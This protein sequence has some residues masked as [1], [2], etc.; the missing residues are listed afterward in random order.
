MLGLRPMPARTPLRPKVTGTLKRDGYVVEK[1]HFQSIP[2]VYVPA[3]LY[4]PASTS[5][6]LPAVLYLC[7]HGIGKASPGYQAH[8][9][10]FAQHGYV[11]MILDTIELG[12]SRGDHHGTYSNGRWDWISRGYTPAGAEVWNAMRA[13]DYLETRPDVDPARFGVTGISGGGGISWFL[14]AADERI[15]CAA[16]CCQTGSV[17]QHVVDRTMDLHCDCAFWIN[18]Y[19][20]CLP[21]IGALIA[22]RPILASAG[23]KDRLWRPYAFRGVMRRIRRQYAALGMPDNAQLVEDITPHSYSPRLRKAIFEWFNQHLKNDPRPV[24]DDVT[25]FV[26]PGR[27]LRAFVNRPPKNDLVRNIDKLLV[28]R[29]ALPVIGSAGRWK[30]HQAATVAAMRSL[31]F[32]NICAKPSPRVVEFRNDGGS[33]LVT[34]GSWVFDTSDNLRLRVRTIIP[35]NRAKPSSVLVYLLPENADWAHY[36][37]CFGRLAEQIAMA[38]VEARNSSSTSIGPGLL[39]TL[40][41]CYALLGH[42]LS[43]LRIGDLL[44]GMAV[45]RRKMNAPKIILYGEGA[46]GVLAIYAA[47]LDG[48]V[49]ELVLKDLPHSHE[50]PL[51]PDIPGI[52]KFGDLPHN[53]ALA[54]PCPITFVG[55]AHPAYRWTLNLYR[56]LGKGRLV[57]R[58]KSIS[59][60]QPYG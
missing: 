20:W 25:D 42:T 17:E 16:A 38:Q 45:V 11:S 22:P 36:A 51:T 28:R 54:F 57:R 44:D 34:T 14:A 23:T 8:P 33:P 52:L 5:A 30:K 53:L 47:L 2:G 9:R 10:W 56:K 24:T 39:W 19:R 12:E 6:R 13:M 40:R 1:L 43:E 55:N 50:N 46:T 31:S 18:Y 4:R 26:E 35:I 60:W 41:R 27:N 59:D 21:D 37:G 15:K 49:S 29:A 3:N 48:N 7:G 32:R 58:V